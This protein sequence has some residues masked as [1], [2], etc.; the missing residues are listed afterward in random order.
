[1]LLSA[2]FALSFSVTLLKEQSRKDVVSTK[3]KKQ[4]TWHLNKFINH[5]T[6]S[7]GGCHKERIFFPPAKCFRF[8]LTI[9]LNSTLTVLLLFL[10]A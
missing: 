7:E 3:K 6:K 1:M 5:L 10:Q 9:R 4:K 2:G 8:E